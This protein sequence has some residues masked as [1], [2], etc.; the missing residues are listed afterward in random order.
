VSDPLAQDSDGDGMP[1]VWET[2]HEFKADDPGDAVLDADDDGQSNL[3]EYRAGTDPRDPKSL[4][5]ITAMVRE[6]NNVEVTWTTVPSHH[7]LLQDGTNLSGA[8]TNNASP[9]ISIPPAG[10]ETTAFTHSNA[11]TL[12]ERF[13]RVRLIGE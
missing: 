1:D 6:S 9:L 11:A 2:A 5:R 7:Y 12:P 13:Y 10:P 8:L 4:L 3:A